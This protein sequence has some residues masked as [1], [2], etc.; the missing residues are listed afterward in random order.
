ME[1]KEVLVEMEK[2]LISVVIPTY[3]QDKFIADTLESV[4][5]QTYKDLDIIVADDASQDKTVQIVEEFAS[6]DSRIR[7]LKSQQNL[8]IPAN[9]NRAFDACI[10]EFVAFLGGDDLMNPDKLER[11]LDILRAHSECSLVLC[12]MAIINEDGGY[13]RKLSD[14]GKIPENALD[15]ALKVDWNFETKWAGVV[16]SSVLARSEYYLSA[17]YT[18]SLYLKHEL[19]FSLESHC[20]HP[21]KKWIL[22]PECL[23]K[24]RIHEENFSRTE[25]SLNSILMDSFKLAQIARSRCPELESR[26]DE[27]E[28]Y[29]AYRARIFDFSKSKEEYEIVRDALLRHA[30]KVKKIWIDFGYVLSKMG[31]YGLFKRLNRQFNL[32]P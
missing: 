9:F 8:G 21:S 4:I 19:L 15:W 23:G 30:G 14:D 5:T 22:I 3:N 28:Y 29:T 20:K 2:G 6:S 18:D 7:I 31:L 26:V 11:Q 10:G 16:P 17:R 13:I 1:G 32:I 27:F 25:D 24:Y 12:D